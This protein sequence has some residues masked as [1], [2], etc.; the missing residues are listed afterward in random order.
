MDCVDQVGDAVED[1]AGGRFFGELTEPALDE[2]EP[3]ARGRGEVEVEAGVL[4]QP[5]ID[6][7]VLV[8]RGVRPGSDPVTE[9]SQ[10]RVTSYSPVRDIVSNPAPVAIDVARA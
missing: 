10:T 9:M 7:G 5:G 6:V 4:G 3:G 8:W 2:V 1:A